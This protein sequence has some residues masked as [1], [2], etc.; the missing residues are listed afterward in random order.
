M[1]QSDPRIADVIAS[2]TIRLAL[3]LPQFSVDAATREVKGHGPGLIAIELMRALTERIGTTLQIVQC[4]TPTKAVEDLENGV[5]DVAFAGIAP[6][7]AKVVDFTPPVVEF[8]YAFMV[9]AGSTFASLA[10]IDRPGMRIAVV[11][12]HASSLA[13]ARLV[14]QAEVVGWDIPDDAFAHFRDGKVDVFALP[15]VMLLRYA[16]ELPGARVL[17]EPY[18][19]NRLGI[20]IRQGQAERLAFFSEFVEESK[21]SGLIADIIARNRESLP[22]FRVAAAAKT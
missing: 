18:G 7:R 20:A 9:P 8:D 4:A 6:S 17:A 3:F 13:L 5:A 15:R 12:N 10:D 1:P 22:G 14:K 19:F 16:Q 21:A 2:G 11:A